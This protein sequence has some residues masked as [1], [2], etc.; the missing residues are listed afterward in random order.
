M[1]TDVKRVYMTQPG[2]PRSCNVCAFYKLFFD[3][4]QHYWDLCRKAKIGCH[5]KKKILAE[6][7]IETF[8]PFREVRA[9]L[10]PE[11]VAGILDQGSETARTVARQTMAEVRQAVGLPS[12]RTR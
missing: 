2:H 10:S 12:L 7:I 6:R 5:E 9:E 4:W 1:V 3:D 11:Q 8:R